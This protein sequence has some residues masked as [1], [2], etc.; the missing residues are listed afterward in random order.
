LQEYKSK[1][2]KVIGCL[3]MLLPEELLHA[4]GAVPFGLWGAEMKIERAK[5]YFP[6]FFCGILQADLEMALSGYLDDLDAVVL[7]QLCDSLKC[8]S[9]NFR[10]AV[11]KIKTICLQQPQNREDPSAKVF[12][13]KRYEKMLSEAE[14]I[15]G[16]KAS[17][18]D[19]AKSIAVYNENRKLLR[20]F[21]ALA[22]SHPKSVSPKKR[23]D[24]IKCGY[25]SDRI[26]H[27][28]LLAAINGELSAMPKEKWFGKRVV[29]CGILADYPAILGYFSA[30]KV[31]VAADDVAHESW[32]YR[33]DVQGNGIDAL[34]DYYFTI[35]GCS[36]L[37]RGGEEREKILLQL[38][39]E[40]KA[41]GV[42]FLPTKFCDPEE[43]DFP[44]LKKALE[45]EEIPYITIE[46]DK[47]ISNY[48]QAQT[49]IQT[50]AE[51]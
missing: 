49:L 38:V 22:A 44:F 36:L 25:F 30:N 15:C 43:Y 10:S 5:R 6:A 11:P 50:F 4:C 12:L 18:E 42:I 26:E 9:Q 40:S 16:V 34:V 19:I 8:F 41:D 27:N 48:G 32:F 2:K 29:T 35:Q 31:A 13:R 3:P 17:E 1:G 39:E 47:T 21:S 46:A 24:V 45:R 28:R 20:E 51:L 7:T 14:E 37:Y 33:H 23:S